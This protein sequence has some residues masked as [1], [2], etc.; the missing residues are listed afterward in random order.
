MTSQ[1]IEA[2]K[3]IDKVPANRLII[4]KTFLEWIVSDDKITAK[5]LKKITQGEKE[6]SR[7]ESSQWRKVVRTI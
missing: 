5:D 7:G 1:I 4:V 3:L 2:K 6:I